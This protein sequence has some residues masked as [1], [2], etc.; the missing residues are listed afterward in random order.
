MRILLLGEYSN[1]HNTLKIGLKKNGHEVLL[2][3]RKDGFKNYDVDID[4]D[5]ADT[6]E[7]KVKTVK[8]SYFT[9]EVNESVD[10]VDSLIGQD[11][12]DVDLSD[13][14][15]RYTQAISKFNK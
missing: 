15:S 12:Q 6:F 4:F 9:K 1:F 5:D 13:S 10:E 7:M 11:S 2:A 8:E 14:M 3:G